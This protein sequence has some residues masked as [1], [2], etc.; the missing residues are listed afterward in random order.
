MCFIFI[1]A[2]SGR[3]RFLL[4]ALPSAV[5][6]KR[7]LQTRTH[8]SSGLKN[9]S[10]SRYGHRRTVKEEKTSSGT[11]VAVLLE[12]CSCTTLVQ[13]SLL[14]TFPSKRNTHWTSSLRDAHT[15]TCLAVVTASGQ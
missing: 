2:E 4:D 5:A 10:P 14:P 1:R 7:A 12:A 15:H 13:T 8:V 3:A 11:A 6:C 9:R